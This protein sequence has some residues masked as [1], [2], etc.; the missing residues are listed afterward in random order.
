MTRTLV[1]FSLLIR[2]LSLDRQ[3]DNSDDCDSLFGDSGYVSPS[4]TSLPLRL[5]QVT[6]S[7]VRT[8]YAS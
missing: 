8:I 2:P 5:A 3:G 1:G 4:S 7:Q 6:D